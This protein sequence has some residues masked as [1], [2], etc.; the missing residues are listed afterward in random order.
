[1]DPGDLSHVKTLRHPLPNMWGP[2]CGLVSVQKNFVTIVTRLGLKNGGKLIPW[3][4]RQP[5][6]LGRQCLFARSRSAAIAAR[7]GQ[8]GDRMTAW[9]AAVHESVVGTFETSRLRRAMSEFE[10]KA[11]NIC[12][13]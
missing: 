6:V 7:P 12:S 4:P 5:R 8:R 11:E 10:G 3:R 1:M 13:H 2:C 9:F